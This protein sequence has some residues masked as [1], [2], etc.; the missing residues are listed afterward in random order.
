VTVASTIATDY[1][2]IDGIEAVTFTD[3]SGNATTGVYAFRSGLSYRETVM[4][5]GGAYQPTD[6]VFELW[7]ATLGGEIPTEGATITDSGSIVYTIRSAVETAIGSTS[8]KWRCVCVKQ[9]A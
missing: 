2:H 3:T 4:A 8:I 5:A 7:S 1:Q 6:I 9:V